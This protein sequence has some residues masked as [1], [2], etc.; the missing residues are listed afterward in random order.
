MSIE[1]FMLKTK[2]T[3]DDTNNDIIQYLYHFLP[4]IEEVHNKSIES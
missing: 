4:E 1:D 3:F 2:S